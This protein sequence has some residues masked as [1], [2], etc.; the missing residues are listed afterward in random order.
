MHNILKSFKYTQ[1]LFRILLNYSNH[2]IRRCDYW[3]EYDLSCITSVTNVAPWNYNPRCWEFVAV[4]L[5]NKVLCCCV[6]LTI[7]TYKLYTF[8]IYIYHWDLKM[9]Q[10]ASC[11]WLL[12]TRN[13]LFLGFLCQKIPIRFFNCSHVVYFCRKSIEITINPAECPFVFSQHWT[14]SFVLRMGLLPDT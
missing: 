6:H 12:I 10:N 8:R 4:V 11:G 3:F 5:C 14:H 2:T 1:Y 9:I 13:N 7:C